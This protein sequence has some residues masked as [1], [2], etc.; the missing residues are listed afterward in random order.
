MSQSLRLLTS[1][2]QESE[3]SI[4]IGGRRWYLVDANILPA[5]TRQYACVSYAFGQETLT[6]IIYSANT[7]S[8]RTVPVLETVQAI[9]GQ[10]D[11]ALWIDSFC[12]SRHGNLLDWET[13]LDE[14]GKIYA[15]AKRVIVVLSPGSRQFL[16][17]VGAKK[18]VLLGEGI[19]A[20]DALNQDAW[21]TRAW[22]YQEV[23][24]VSH[25]SDLL[26]VAEGE[27]ETAV[28][29][30]EFFDTLGYIKQAYQQMVVEEEGHSPTMSPELTVRL[31]FMNVDA[32]EDVLVDAFTA[33]YTER[34]AL[35]VMSNVEGRQ[36]GRNE[37]YFTA[38][39]GAITTS[40]AERESF[41]KVWDNI[42][43]EEPM[44]NYILQPIKTA[45]AAERFMQIC[46]QKGDFSFIFTVNHRSK[47]RGQGWRPVP[48]GLNVICAW[49]SIGKSQPGDFTNGRLRLSGLWHMN[50]EVVDEPASHFIDTWITLRNPNKGKEGTQIGM[51][52]ECLREIGFMGVRSPHDT[53][54]LQLGYFVPQNPCS[55]ITGDCTVF[56]S[57]TI[58]WVFGAPGILVEK[59][60]TVGNTEKNSYRF[61]SVGMF[62]GDT[63]RAG[64]A[65]AINVV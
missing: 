20:L 5:D 65:E 2:P 14:M 53:I 19:P 1:T 47:R 28:N 22:T 31:R 48:Q 54:S 42:T 6:N 40:S 13:R 17:L 60:G 25:I 3:Y 51:V 49:P 63:S 39:V 45:F 34:S 23:V 33:T 7:M 62:V 56:V 44:L 55:V 18:K 29:G 4:H 16:R 43:D 64:K 41:R 11:M 30:R 37:D 26:F 10:K 38:M 15:H 46:E 35:Q 50:N 12:L 27:P 58:I 59:V 9:I 52:L 61:I 8:A 57:S 24:N 21:V 36:V 32:L